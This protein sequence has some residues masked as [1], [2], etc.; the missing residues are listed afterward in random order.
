MQSNLDLT[1]VRVSGE[2]YVIRFEPRN[3]LKVFDEI[4][5]KYA[6]FGTS[7]PKPTVSTICTKLSSHHQKKKCCD[8]WH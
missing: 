2:A 3:E 4:F 5:G 8:V 1:A 6:R 7:K